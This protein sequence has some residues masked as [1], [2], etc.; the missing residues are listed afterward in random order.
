M[1]RCTSVHVL[2]AVVAYKHSHGSLHGTH[3]WTVVC[4]TLES[5]KRRVDHPA[6]GRTALIF[7]CMWGHTAVAETL[8]EARAG[9]E[10]RS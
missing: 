10:C 7:A 6:S 9:L 5:F 4:L 8:L 3:L 1:R 2:V